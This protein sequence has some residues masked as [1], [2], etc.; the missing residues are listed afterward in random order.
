MTIAV[1]GNTPE[2]S[3]LELGTQWLGGQ[4]AL[5]DHPVD[6]HGLGG[7]IKLVESIV[8]LDVIESILGNIPSDHKLVF[9]FSV[10]AG[11]ATVTKSQLKQR[12]QELRNLGM[13]LKK[14][15][16]AEGRSVRFVVSD[17]V[18][19]SSV[20]VT[21]EHLLRDQTDFIV[22]LF[23][24]RTVYGRTTAVQD[25][26]TFSNRDFGRPQRDTF[27][28]MLPP[29]VARMMLNI[30]HPKPTDTILDPFCGSGTVIQEALSL[31]FT[32]VTGSDISKKCIDDTTAN[33]H[34][35]IEQVPTI[36]TDDLNLYQHDVLQ[37]SKLLPARS[38]NVIVAEG[39]L[40]PVQLQNLDQI[41]PELTQF[42]TN[43]FAELAKI[44][45]TDARLV[46]ALPNWKQG[47]QIKD[48]HLDNAIRQAGFKV[49]HAPILYGRPDARV[50]RKIIFIQPA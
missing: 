35:L 34:W 5:L 30:A 14:R 24:D 15:L 44:V 3:A 26:K 22:G 36:N 11:D 39:Y 9:G 16:K 38:V 49:W 4:L 10:Y 48:M 43:M 12:A 23:K 25:F 27:S 17:D 29:K 37:L 8:S 1:L 7:T 31:G 41:I 21:K 33:V 42:Y 6:I 2:L 45:T 13:E 20:I 28:G 46:L 40:G 50:V 19:L 47:D 18:A 32:K